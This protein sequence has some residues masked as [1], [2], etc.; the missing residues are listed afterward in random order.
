MTGWASTPAPD[1]ASPPPVRH[2]AEGT[3]GPERPGAR[4]PPPARPGAT[5][6][7]RYPAYSRQ[8]Q[9]ASSGVLQGERS[10]T[11]CALPRLWR[12]HPGAYNE[13]II[14]SLWRHYSTS[15]AAVVSSWGT[16]GRSRSLT[17]AGGTGSS[18]ESVRGY[19]HGRSGR[20]A[21]LLT[22]PRRTSACSRLPPASA[23][24]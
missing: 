11:S 4:V 24:L 2:V 12:V 14:Q 8:T 18:R 13:K 19:P 5:H 17:G 22:A 23:L 21:A 1:R 9:N 10:S 20:S 7:A 3:P 15:A 6:G 16:C